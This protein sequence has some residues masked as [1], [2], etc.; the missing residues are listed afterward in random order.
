MSDNVYTRQQYWGNYEGKEAE[1]G[2]IMPNA[3]LPSDKPDKGAKSVIPKTS[4]ADSSLDMNEEGVTG[5][6]PEGLP[7]AQ[8]INPR[9]SIEG[10]E[11]PKVL[12]E[13]QA[14][15]FA[16]PSLRRYPLDSYADVKL[17]SSYFHD[18]RDVMLP[19]HRHEFCQNLVK[20]AEALAILVSDEIQKYGSARYAPHEE[21]E[22][23]LFS[24]RS[25]LLDD[26]HKNLLSKLAYKRPS[27]TPEDFAVTLGEF[28]KLAGIDH[29]YDHEV[30][31]PYY[32]TFGKEAEEDGSFVIG[33]DLV[34]HRQLKDFAK[35]GA[36]GIEKLF[37]C[38][39]LKEFRD[40]PIA[41]FKS[42]PVDQQKVVSRLAN[43]LDTFG[44]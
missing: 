6:Q 23:A 11:P 7:Q 33:N 14:Q 43:E 41:I 37:G 4:S 38:D 27:L 24:R 29:L 26:D 30:I 3:S 28:D 35:S 44:V 19:A 12:T 10:K 15:Y 20:R 32:T 25:L 31:D 42:L 40:D 9:V 34:T 21:F 17:A 36:D 39:F 1:V 8:P 16:L 18:Y 13:K 22:A 5:E 2:D